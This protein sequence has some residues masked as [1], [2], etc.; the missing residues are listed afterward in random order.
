MAEFSKQ[1]AEKNDPN[2]PWDFDILEIAD[3]LPNENY[4]PYICEGYGFIA[5]GKTGNGEILLA[6]PNHDNDTVLWKTFSEVIN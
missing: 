2:F 3:S 4:L 6:I 1:W 5:I